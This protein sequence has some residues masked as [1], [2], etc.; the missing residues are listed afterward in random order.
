MMG[1][2]SDADANI[3]RSMGYRPIERTFKSVTDLL[4]PFKDRVHHSYNPDEEPY[5]IYENTLVTKLPNITYLPNLLTETGEIMLATTLGHQH[6]QRDKG[7]RRPFQEIYEFL[8]YGAMLL[9]DEQRARFH[10][11][12]PGDKITTGTGDSMTFFNLSESPLITY[13][14]ANPKMNSAHKDLEKDIGTMMFL[15]F[16]NGAFFVDINNTYYSRG[17]VN[18]AIQEF[19]LPI[20]GCKLGQSLYEELSRRL[21]VYEKLFAVSGIELQIGGN[22]PPELRDEF[23]DP[24]LTL[25][26]K[27][28]RSLLDSLGFD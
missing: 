22:L 6:T 16:Y 10:V 13:D 23:K 21:A 2:L 4:G 14:M 1:L 18:G 5:L 20:T 12:Q 11:L 7:D 19:P 17:L 9:R 25:V 26:L 28:N 3:L 24:L 15:T 8:G 27:R